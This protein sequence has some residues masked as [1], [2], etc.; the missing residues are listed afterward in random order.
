MKKVSW[1]D[2]VVAIPTVLPERQRYL[3]E[4]IEQVTAACPG[5]RLVIMPHVAGTPARVD[6]PKVLQAA[7]RIEGN[8]VLQLEDDVYL[9]PTFGEAA[10]AAML[11][12]AEVVTLFS[13]SVED[14][15]ALARGERFRRITPS[16]FS[17]SQA[18]LV[19]SYLVEDLVPF[20]EGWY[21]RNPQH[22][23]GAD[24][25]FGAWLSNIRAR[26]LV[27]VPSLVQH[28][29]GPSTLPNH[30]GA[31]QSESY[32]AAFGEIP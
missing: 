24:L 3:N 23:R 32:R 12:E 8:W 13:R 7:G 16:S 28:R 27:S 17:M 14:M 10:L 22:N 9:A 30:N 11:E 5:A 31:R 21:G 6:F 2:V 15:A 18:F 1:T 20:A 19:R 4:L 25:L 26:V 29:R